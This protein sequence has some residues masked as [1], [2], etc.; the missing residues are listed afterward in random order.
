MGVS[1]ERNPVANARNSTE[2]VLLSLFLANETVDVSIRTLT[3]E[4]QLSSFACS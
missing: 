4:E 1:Y 3:I 2:E